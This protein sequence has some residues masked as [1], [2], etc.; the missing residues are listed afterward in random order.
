MRSDVKI[1]C[2]LADDIGKDFERLSVVLRTHSYSNSRQKQHALL[3]GAGL[4]AID[5][6]LRK[7]EE[8]EGERYPELGTLLEFAGCRKFDVNKLLEREMGTHSENLS[9]KS[10]MSK[11][12]LDASSDNTD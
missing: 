3:I 12:S 6:L 8:N 10:A 4:L 1:S 11:A 9:L 5:A 2:H 7:Y